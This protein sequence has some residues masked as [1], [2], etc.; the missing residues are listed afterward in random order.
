[1]VKPN[2]RPVVSKHM[3]GTPR[4]YSIVRGESFPRPG[5]QSYFV[6]H[7]STKDG[8][9]PPVS[10]VYCSCDKVSQCSCVPVCTCQAV[11]GCVGHTACSCNSHS[12]GSYSSGCRCAPVH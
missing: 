8:E 1:M 5:L 4:I 6:D 12:S 10:G 2:D 7:S 9:A 11:C 3:T